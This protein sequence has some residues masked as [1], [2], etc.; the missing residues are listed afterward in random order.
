MLADCMKERF[1]LTEVKKSEK[2]FGGMKFLCT[3]AVLYDT[4]T[5]QQSQKPF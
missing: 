4:T 3:F 5:P 1:L 2:N